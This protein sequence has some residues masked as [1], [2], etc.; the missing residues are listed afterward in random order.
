[1]EQEALPSS[2]KIFQVYFHQGRDFRLYFHSLQPAPRQVTT[3]RLHYPEQLLKP[4]RPAGAV[5]QITPLQ[6]NNRQQKMNV[7]QNLL[8]YSNPNVKNLIFEDFCW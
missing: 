6:R 5:C 1:M 7:K 4:L 2:E 8:Q 3:A